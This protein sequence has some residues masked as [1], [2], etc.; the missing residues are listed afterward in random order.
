MHASTEL[1]TPHPD[2]CTLENARI[3]EVLD[4][5]MLREAGL[6]RLQPPRAPAPVPPPPLHGSAHPPVMP[7]TPLTA[8]SS[9]NSGP[10]CS[11]RSTARVRSS[12]VSSSPA[13]PLPPS[14]MSELFETNFLYTRAREWYVWVRAHA[15]R[16]YIYSIAIF[17]GN[18][19]S[20]DA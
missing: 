12:S 18:E 13:P 5:A 1:A 19:L 14:I 20:L 6:P 16:D 7:P 15:G 17:F 10:A 11:R 4:L 3:S 9:V 8:S 2:A